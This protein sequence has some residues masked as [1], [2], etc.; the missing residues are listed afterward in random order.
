MVRSPKSRFWGHTVLYSLCYLILTLFPS[1]CV[2]KL[3]DS[4]SFCSNLNIWPKLPWPFGWVG[5]LAEFRKL[6]VFCTTKWGEDWGV[7]WGIFKKLIRVFPQFFSQECRYHFL[8]IFWGCFKHIPKTT[9]GSL[10][11]W[12]FGSFYFFSINFWRRGGGVKKCQ[13][14]KLHH[15]FKFESY[16]PLLPP[17]F[18]YH[19]YHLFLNVG[20]YITGYYSSFTNNT[21]H[22]NRS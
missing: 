4:L 20:Y 5:H 3:L 17:R 11:L 22:F 15:V 14:R 21:L 8:Q 7:P 16:W 19:D 9:L 1:K 10:V 12:Y 18:D 13:I 2:A 6:L